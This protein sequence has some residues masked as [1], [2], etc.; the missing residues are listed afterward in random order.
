MQRSEVILHGVTKSEIEELLRKALDESHDR[1]RIIFVDGTYLYTFAVADVPFVNK[2]TSQI[3]TGEITVIE[4]GREVVRRNP[5]V[6][7]WHNW[8]ELW[9]MGYICTNLWKED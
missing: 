9:C 6:I 7:M 8:L 1:N 3:D 5:Q 2:F 4:E